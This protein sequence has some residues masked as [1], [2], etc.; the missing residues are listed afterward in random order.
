MSTLVKAVSNR[1]EIDKM[2]TSWDRFVRKNTDNPYL[3]HEF[4][5][6][7][8]EMKYSGI[9]DPLFLVGHRDKE[10]IGVAPL[11]TRS[12]FGVRVARS[13]LRP[14]PSLIVN[15]SA[16]YG[17]VNGILEMLFRILKCKSA[18][19]IIQ[20]EI[21]DLSTIERLCRVR[22]TSFIAKEY[23]GCRI[24]TVED[25]WEHFEKSRGRNFR[26]RFRKMET[27]LNNAGV[28]RATMVECEEDRID[29]LDKIIE[30]DRLSWKEKWRSGKRVGEDPDLLII[31][32]AA[33]QA[34]KNVPGFKSR[35]WIL[36]LNDH[37]IAFIWALVN[38]KTA[39]LAKTSYDIRFHDFYPGM[40]VTHTAIRNLFN[41]KGVHSIDF[42]TDLPYHRAW[43]PNLQDRRELFLGNGFVA[44][45]MLSFYTNEHIRKVMSGLLGSSLERNAD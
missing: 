12:V 45:R 8:M 36:E 31:W 28:C 5:N 18:N 25:S 24:M 14:Y 42:I 21:S 32:R 33:V 2:G 23:M 19:L 41:D 3:L 29:V 37:P 20:N 6:A 35:I 10:I 38:G 4:V 13:V 17:F 1:N 43:V 26:N 22:G 30:I 44:K 34:T 7:Y 11:M 16:L 40:Y 9:W 27:K 39:T 15:N